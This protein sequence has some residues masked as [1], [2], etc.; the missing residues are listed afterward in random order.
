MKGERAKGEGLNK[1]R[2]KNRK[3]E[4]EKERKK[5]QYNNIFQFNG[6]YSTQDGARFSRAVTNPLRYIKYV[7][8]T[9]V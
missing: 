3:K 2:K 7:L 4:K 5:N 9:V 8:N 1:G 6:F